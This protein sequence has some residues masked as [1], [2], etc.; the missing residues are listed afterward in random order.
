MGTSV[1]VRCLAQDGQWA[2]RLVLNTRRPIEHWTGQWAHTTVE[3]S[4]AGVATLVQGK[5]GDPN[6][7]H[8]RFLPAF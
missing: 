3:H 6:H 1:S 7:P 2:H 4:S 5:V 8:P